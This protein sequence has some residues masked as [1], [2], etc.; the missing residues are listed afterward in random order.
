M[1]DRHCK[2]NYQHGIKTEFAGVSFRSR[3]EARWAACF[4]ALAWEWT[5]EPFDLEG[6]IPDFVLHFPNPVLV[7]AKPASSLEELRGYTSKIDATTWQKEVLLVGVAPFRGGSVFSDSAVIGLLRD[8]VQGWDSATAFTCA[9]ACVQDERVGVRGPTAHIGF[10][11]DFGVWT[12]RVCDVYC[13]DHH[14]EKAETPL[15]DEAWASAQNRTQW[16]GSQP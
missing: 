4:H 16:R 8:G 2:P 6:W 10:L 14:I 9:G 5:Y 3:L 7:E 1:A 15:L 12:C 13:G 11:H